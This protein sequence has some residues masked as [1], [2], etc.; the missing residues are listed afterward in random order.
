MTARARDTFRGVAWGRHGED[1]W[2][3]HSESWV[4][5]GILSEGQAGEI[6]RFEVPEHEQQTAPALGVTA[7]VLVYVGSLLALMSGVVLVAGSW[8]QLAF[9]GRLAIGLGV[10][11]IAFVAGGMLDDDPDGWST[12]WTFGQGTP[13]LT[14]VPVA[15]GPCDL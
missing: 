1:W 9:A 15:G 6:R 8:E 10:T 2:A 3:E 14:V 13:G 11:L 12:R 7:E 5:A 4:E